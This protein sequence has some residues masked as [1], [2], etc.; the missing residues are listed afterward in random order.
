M[1][2][3]NILCIGGAN[4]DWIG[5]YPGNSFPAF[6]IPIT[7]KCSFGGVA[8]NIAQNLKSLG[9]DVGF[10]S[11]VGMDIEGDQI[12][13]EIGSS[14]FTEKL[15]LQLANQKTASILFVVN[16]Q[17]KHLFMQPRTEIYDFLTPELIE[18]QSVNMKK[19]DTWVIDTNLSEEAIKYIVNIKPR[20][21]KL[22]AVIAC[23][24]KSKKI[25]PAL[26][27]LDALFLNQT[28]A[29]LILSEEIKTENALLAADEIRKT[30]VKTVFLTLGEHG[31]CVSAEQS[32]KSLPILKVNSID[33]TGA[34]DAFAAGAIS[35]LI[36]QKSA[37]DC[38]QQ[39]LAA[40][41]L[42]VEVKSKTYGMLSSEKINQRGMINE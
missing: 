18:T 41:S 14:G 13:A 4:I 11:A 20:Q 42:A 2:Q 5:Q 33:T 24:P 21:T 1:G 32:Q 34:G 8:H 9:H 15:L 27:H 17:G 40:A 31:A 37:I 38:L 7:F 30:G 39:G 36:K 35:G 16:P 3:N 19:F 28:E 29:S 23:P 22:Y 26:A 12:I 6:D 10:M 25:T